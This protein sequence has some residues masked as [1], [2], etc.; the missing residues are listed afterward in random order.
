MMSWLVVM[1]GSKGKEAFRNRPLR[2]LK[3]RQEKAQLC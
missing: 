1:A 3:L 2:Q